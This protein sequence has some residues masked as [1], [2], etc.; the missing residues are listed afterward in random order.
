MSI[1]R[2][3]FGKKAK[4]P[5]YE[6][7]VRSYV[8]QY[9]EKPVYYTVDLGLAD[10]AVK[11]EFSVYVAV[12]LPAQILAGQEPPVSREEL[13]AL[14][15]LE[16]DAFADAQRVGYLY[17][18]RA[19]VT[20]A[21]H[22]YIAFYCRPEDKQAVTDSLNRICQ[23]RGRTPTM[24]LVKDDPEWLFYTDR[25]APDEHKLQHINHMDIL[26][27]LKDHGDDSA[28]ARPVYFWLYTKTREAGEQIAA[29]AKAAGMESAEI[30][31]SRESEEGPVDADRPFAVQLTCTMAPTL[32]GLN[33]KAWKLI[34]LARAHEGLYDGA[35]TE[36]VHAGVAPSTPE[37]A[38]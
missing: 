7:H 14:H 6:S 4:L 21:E 29:E 27:E 35:E 25:L 31:D 34:D 26:Q 3:L 15:T 2:T 28:A 5:A 36:V 17:A 32:D 9:E 23:R 18:G 30:T 19:I 13:D 37:Q 33:A 10:L 24:V 20:A 8:D 1:F 11:D 16:A 22:M 38:Q 12:I